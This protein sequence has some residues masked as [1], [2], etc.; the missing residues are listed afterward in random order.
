MYWLIVALHICF[1][2]FYVYMIIEM[3]PSATILLL[4]VAL[5]STWALFDNAVR[6]HES[7]VIAL[8]FLLVGAALLYGACYAS[9]RRAKVSKS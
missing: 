6:G 4:V 1:A 2:L 5:V 9:A 7:F 8:V 3:E